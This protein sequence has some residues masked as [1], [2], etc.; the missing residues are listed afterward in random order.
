[1]IHFALLA[2]AAQTEATTQQGVDA[3]A[4]ALE[5]GIYAAIIVV[6]LVVL[7][8]LHRK[9]KLPPHTELQRRLNVLSSD[10][11]GLIGACGSADLGAYA[12]FKKISK[13]LYQ[14]DSLVYIS[15]LLSE[16][17]RDGDI[18]N[19]AILLE[20]A[21]DDISPYK[22]HAK[23]QDDPGGLYEAQE[24][25]NNA[26]SIIQKIIGR[27]SEMIEEKKGKRKK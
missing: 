7:W 26:F 17:E 13:L 20:N 8:F 15:T 14:T 19:I 6:G 27:D 22:F 5:Y 10:I 23:T 16:K 24:K 2:E 9:S 21:R 25:V 4:L 1:M 18:G 11:D 12:F 3:A